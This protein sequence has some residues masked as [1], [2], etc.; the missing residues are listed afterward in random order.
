MD[1]NYNC[2][3]YNC[4]FCI[5]YINTLQ[6]L[7]DFHQTNC[8]EC[9]DNEFYDEED[10]IYYHECESCQYFDLY[11][12]LY[13]EELEENNICNLYITKALIIQ[14]WFRK[15]KRNKILWKIAD[16]YTKKK[17]HPNSTFIKRY[18]ETFNEKY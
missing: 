8:I 10:N 9:F 7:N 1:Y 4:E 2:D 16:Y 3:F 17:Y 18:M 14:Q 13:I 12:V 15:I 5:N 11:T 6:E